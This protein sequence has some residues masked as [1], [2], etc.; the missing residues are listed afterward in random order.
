MQNPA[1]DVA[2]LGED[3]TRRRL[4]QI[5]ARDPEVEGLF[6]YSVVTT[7]VY[8]RPT[9]PSRRAQPAHIQLHDTLEDARRT[10]FRPCGRCHPEQPSLHAR[11]RILV[12]AACRR[13]VAGGRD[14][15][16]PDLAKAAG[17]S[18]SQFYRVFRR[19]TGLTPAAYARAHHRDPGGTV[20]VLTESRRF[21]GP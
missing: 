13:L 14:A 2:H 12:D 10:G 7:G 16:G 8:C 11:R 20:S 3:V 5:H 15:N 18:P 17:L 1:I 4:A 9:C 19:I 6:W 21:G